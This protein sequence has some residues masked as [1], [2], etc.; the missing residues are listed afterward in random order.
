MRVLD[1]DVHAERRKEAADEQLDPLGF[2]ERASAGQERLEP[3]LIFRDGARALAIDQLEE[4]GGAD[5][6]GGP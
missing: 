4:G 1:P 6:N 2:I 3:V 5:R